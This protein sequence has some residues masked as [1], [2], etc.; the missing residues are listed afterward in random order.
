M[1]N[2]MAGTGDPFGGIGS[3]VRHGMVRAEALCGDCAHSFCEECLVR[4]FGPSKPPLCIGCALRLGGVRSSAAPQRREAER[5]SW[6]ERRARRKLPVLP[7]VAA[8]TQGNLPEPLWEHDDDLASW[9]AS[10]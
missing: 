7:N 10:A 5:V 3:C 2:A 8:D 9:R 6:R 4:P 1:I